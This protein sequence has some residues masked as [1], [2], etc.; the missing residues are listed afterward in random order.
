MTAAAGEGAGA[1][2]M[3]KATLNLVK[4]A[5]LAGLAPHSLITTYRGVREIHLQGDGVDTAIGSIHVGARTGR[6]LRA[7]VAY[8]GDGTLR[9]R[10]VRAGGYYA[11]RRALLG[12]YS[13][14]TVVRYRGS[15]TDHHGIKVVLACGIDGYVLTDRDYPYE[16]FTLARVRPESITATGETTALCDCG[17]ETPGAGRTGTPDWCLYCDCTHHLDAAARLAA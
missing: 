3:N 15:L 6:V 16:Q 17:H 5:M 14:G 12:A 9:S 2:R 4:I 13:P 10:T 7:V 11:A 1:G 8:P